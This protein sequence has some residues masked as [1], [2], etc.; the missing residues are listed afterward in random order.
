MCLNN[1]QYPL[2]YTRLKATVIQLGFK[3][4]YSVF[5]PFIDNLSYGKVADAA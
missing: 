2:F 1:Y 3:A 4:L 5:N